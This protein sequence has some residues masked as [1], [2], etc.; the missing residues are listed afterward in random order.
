MITGAWVEEESIK[1]WDMNT[2]RMLKS[3]NPIN[4]V[5]SIE[6]EFYYCTK[7]H[8]TDPTGNIILAVG[9]GRCALDVIDMENMKII[10]SHRMGKIVLTLDNSDNVVFGGLD[11]VMKIVEVS[12]RSL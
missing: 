2:G 10:G 12:Y 6:G 11:S 5:N 4:V 9:S 8:N 3:V 1:L 7:F